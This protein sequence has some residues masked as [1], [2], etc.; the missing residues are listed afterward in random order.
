MKNKQPSLCVHGVYDSHIHL[1]GTGL[2]LKTL[3]LSILK[4]PKDLLKL[5]IKNQHFR[6]EVLFGFGWDDSLWKKTLWKDSKNNIWGQLNCSYFDILDQYFFKYPVFFVSADGHS[7]WLNSLALNSLG[8]NNSVLKNSSCHSSGLLR[9]NL[10]AVVQNKLQPYSVEQI[11]EAIKSAQTVFNSAGFTH[12]RDMSGEP[13]YWNCLLNMDSS[14]SLRIEQNM[15]IEDPNNFS[16]ALKLARL[17]KKESLINIKVRGVKVYY[18]GSL[19][20]NTALLS[21]KYLDATEVVVAS[22]PLIAAIDLKEMLKQSWMS[23]LDFSIHVIGNKASEDVLKI[24][25]S[26]IEEF[27]KKEIPIKILNL[28]HVQL[29]SQASLAILSR[30]KNIICHLQPCHFLSDKA[31]LKNKLSKEAL[32]DLFVWKQLEDQQQLFYFGSDSPVEPSSLFLNK[33]AL[34]EANN[35]GITNINK[36]WLHYHTHPDKKWVGSSYTTLDEKNQKILE[37]CFNGK[38][39]IKN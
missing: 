31:W 7:A 38:L 10:K 29:L 35:W 22:K 26:V 9:D 28:E 18:D 8:L 20:S 4:S 16:E 6:G 23:N 14:L 21:S 17:A 11:Y 34:M 2:K 24:A 13:D 36:P 25:E 37:V 15:G 33:K 39:I 19:G 5:N 1:L 32:K 27:K 30:Y 3:D 12:V